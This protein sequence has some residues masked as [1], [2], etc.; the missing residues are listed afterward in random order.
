MTRRVIEMPTPAGIGAGQTASV[1]LPLGLTYHSLFIRMN[2][3]AGGV[4]TNVAA[5]DWGTYLENIRVQVNGD[6]KINIKAVDLAKLVQFYGVTLVA[7][8]L[9]LYFSRPWMRTIGGEE[10][11][12]YKTNG[13]IASLT[14]EMEIKAGVTVNSLTVYA[15]QGPGI[16]NEGRPMSW[17]PH[18]EIN[19]FVHTQ[20]VTGDAEISDIPRSNYSMLAMHFNTDEI[21][22]I[23]V[24]VDN[25]KV[26]ETDLAI[27]NMLASTIGRVPQ[28][29]M[30]HIDILKENRLI[31]ALP[32]AVQDFRLKPTFTA[33]GN[34]T[35]YAES[36]KGAAG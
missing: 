31:E 25:R 20:G 33:T 15:D 23:E 8:V 2:V 17:G 3:Q 19:K 24:T 28:T 21:S 14:I 7:G 29:G 11:T 6:T 18:L 35:I 1:S 9:P 12:S 36:I 34:F 26:I 5:A 16:D 27:R 4:A 13:G 22:D 30:T 32:M 10:Q